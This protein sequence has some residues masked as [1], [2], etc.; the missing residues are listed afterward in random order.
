M[1]RLE[2]LVASLLCI[3]TIAMPPPSVFRAVLDLKAL[4][5]IFERTLRERR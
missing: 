4:S 2:L 5:S 1:W 3:Y